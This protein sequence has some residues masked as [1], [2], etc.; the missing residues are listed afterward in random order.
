MQK[1][2]AWAQ[3]GA[4]LPYPGFDDLRAAGRA[5]L[6]FPAVNSHTK[7]AR[8][9]HTVDVGAPCGDRLLQDRYNRGMQPSQIFL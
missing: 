4:A 8:F 7:T 3:M 5:R 9:E 2:A 6:P 1:L